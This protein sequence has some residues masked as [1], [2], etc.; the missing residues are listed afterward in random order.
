MTVRV[1][2]TIIV[3]YR[4]AA[5]L[6][7][8]P[9]SHV[10][11]D[12][13]GSIAGRVGVPESTDPVWR[14]LTGAQ[15]TLLDFGLGK[16]LT[17]SGHDFTKITTTGMAAGTLYYMSPEQIQADKDLDY[18]ADIYGASMLLFRMLN[19]DPP[20]DG[21]MMLQIATSHLEAPPPSLP[22]GLDAHPIGAVY[23]QG[24]MKKRDERYISAAAMAYALRA[25][26]DPALAAQ[27]T[28]AFRSPTG[29]E[30]KAAK[31][32]LWARL[33]GR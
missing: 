32:G 9:E 3:L 15:V 13:H 25:A 1:R 29:A 17:S 18:R 4:D 22:D 28:P 21:Q 10:P 23:R 6:L 24:A 7:G 31:R 19:G 27:P 11:I 33:F 2:G 30:P 26:V 12:P 5:A 20:Y 16:F 8:P 14:D